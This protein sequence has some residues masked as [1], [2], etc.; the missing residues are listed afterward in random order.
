MCWLVYDGERSIL[1]AEYT[2]PNEIDFPR[3][4]MKCSG[5]N[6]CSTMRNISCSIMFSTTFHVISR[7]FGLLFGQCIGEKIF[8]WFSLGVV[9]LYIFPFKSSNF[10]T[11]CK[12]V[13]TFRDPAFIAWMSPFVT[14][15]IQSDWLPSYFPREH[16]N[17][18]AFCLLN[19]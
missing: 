8:C 3:Y 11:I 18:L 16:W 9:I 13:C 2:I 12:F 19:E 6:V 4:N 14:G 5:E 7:K 1:V 17:I 10:C 15:R